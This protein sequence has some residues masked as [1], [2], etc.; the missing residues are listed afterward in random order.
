MASLPLMH[1]HLCLCRNCDC[2]PHDD[3]IVTVIDVQASLPL[4]SWCRHPHNTF[5][6]FLIN[7]P[8]LTKYSIKKDSRVI[9]ASKRT[10][11][12]ADIAFVFLIRPNGKSSCNGATYQQY[13]R[14]QGISRMS[15][16]TNPL[17]WEETWLS[18][19]T[20]PTACLLASEQSHIQKFL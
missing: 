4:S 8:G 19:S 2:C 6:I 20:Q 15:T 14:Y 7:Y 1:R 11:R 12:G 5:N 16:A 17:G 10:L 13:C 18:L 3:G 9:H